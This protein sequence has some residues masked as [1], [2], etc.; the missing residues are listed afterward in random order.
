VNK[1]NNLKIEPLVSIGMPVKNG[2]IN[3][4]NN[5]INL[6]KALNSVLSQSY[7]N[8]EIIISNN[9]STDETKYYLEKIS[10]TDK[11]IKLH[12]QKI[13]ISPGE[14]FKYV[15]D[16]ANG[17]YFKW[18][19]ADDLISENY[20]EKNVEFLEI[21]SDYLFSSSRFYYEDRPKILHSFNLDLDLYSR[22]KGFFDIRHVSH[23]IF[24]SLIRREI[25]SKVTN[26]GM[27]YWAIDWIIN[28]ELL[29]NGKFK[30]I[31]NGYVGFGINGVSRQ[32]SFFDS[33]AVHIKKKI[34]R[35]IPFYE[36]IK[37]IIKKI[38]FSKKL[39][40]IEKFYI[41]FLLIKINLTFHKRYSFK[42][43][44]KLLF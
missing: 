10:K 18:N 16:Q 40:L 36:L 32:T 33:K 6:T 19:A 35:I 41:Y 21:N 37:I 39:S 17:K 12:N 44:K 31:N 42:V 13:E 26:V 24:Y 29:L 20:I 28:L 9:C 2:F 7:K 25:M 3:K 34:Y 4:H 5:N 15:L 38:T 11:R 43:I 8:I 22:I 1:I 27:D 23:N 30:T 14:N